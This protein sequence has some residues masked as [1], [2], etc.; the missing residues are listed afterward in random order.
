M[1]ARTL[2]GCLGVIGGQPKPYRATECLRKDY[3]LLREFL[4]ADMIYTI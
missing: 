4:N 3:A 1:R 2:L